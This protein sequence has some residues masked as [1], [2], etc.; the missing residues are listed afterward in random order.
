MYVYCNKPHIICLTDPWWSSPKEPCLINYTPFYNHRTTATGG[1]TAIL[2]RNDFIC[3][4]N[5]LNKYDDGKL[6]IKALTILF[7][8][9]QIDIM[10]ICNPNETITKE[11]FQ[12]YFN[13]LNT[14][15]FITGDFNAKILTEPE[16]TW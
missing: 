11:E 16:K 7:E 14:S 2:L 9:D 5:K 15:H 1:G 8:N 3:I 13:Q 10:N 12:F 4:D 6:E